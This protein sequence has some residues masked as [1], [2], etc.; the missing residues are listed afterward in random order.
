MSMKI[1]ILV[2]TM[3]GT[4]QL[5]AQEMELAL[6]DGETQVSTLMMGSLDSTVSPREGIFLICTSPYGQ[7]DGPD[8]ARALYVALKAKRPDLSR[9]RYGVFGLGDR[10]YDE[11][12][13]FGGKRF[14]DMLGE[15]AA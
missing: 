12:F 11:T 2:G 13:K 14:G 10:H 5:C 7:G 1:N 3:T 4:A 8:T 15:L 9:V 6:D